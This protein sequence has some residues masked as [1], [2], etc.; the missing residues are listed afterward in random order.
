MKYIPHRKLGIRLPCIQKDTWNT[1]DSCRAWHGPYEIEPCQG[2]RIDRADDT[3]P[4]LARTA[5]QHGIFS[6]TGQRLYRPS[7]GTGLN[8][9][10]LVLL[11]E[12]S[13]KIS[14]YS[15]KIK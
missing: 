11:W 8:P 3:R 13:W 7:P 5:L 12:F 6:R 10:K 9:T 4:R 15:D 1:G 14:A 2:K